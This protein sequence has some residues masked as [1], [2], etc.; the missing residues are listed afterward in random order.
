MLYTYV[1]IYTYSRY[2]TQSNLQLSQESWITCVWS[3]VPVFSWCVSLFQWS[4][5]LHLLPL[6]LS[7]CLWFT[8][9]IAFE[10]LLQTK[11]QENSESTS[12]MFQSSRWLLLIDCLVHPTA[13]KMLKVVEFCK[14]LEQKIEGFFL[15]KWLKLTISWL[16]KI[17]I[18]RQPIDRI[19]N[20]VVSGPP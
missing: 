16:G 17:I 15:D 10:A 3:S 13:L 14:N 2:T 20:R 19:I 7:V 8:C 1:L 5:R 12:I 18:F 6:A 4:G 9:L 11:C